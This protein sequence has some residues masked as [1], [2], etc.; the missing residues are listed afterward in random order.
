MSKFLEEIRSSLAGKK[1]TSV[2]VQE[3]LQKWGLR[4]IQL[5]GYQLDGVQWLIQNLQNQQG[6]ILGD[7]MGLGKTCQVMELIR[8][9]S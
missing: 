3:D 1:K 4:G 8:T 6:C 7:E 9:S 2:V 5:R